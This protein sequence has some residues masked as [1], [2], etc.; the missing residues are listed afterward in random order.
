MCVCVC[1]IQNFDTNMFSI[2]KQRYEIKHVTF[3]T[4]RYFL[5]I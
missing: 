5:L 4:S 3:D 2:Y 1:Q